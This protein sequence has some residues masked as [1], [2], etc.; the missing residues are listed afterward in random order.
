MEYVPYA[1]NLVALTSITPPGKLSERRSSRR[2][3]A[4]HPIYKF[5]HRC[6]F[7]SFLQLHSV[8]NSRHPSSS[9]L[10]Q[11]S[12]A[13]GVDGRDEGASFGTV[14]ALATNVIPA[15]SP[16]V[17]YAGK[18]RCRTLTSAAVLCSSVT[19]KLT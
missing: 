17:H 13:V 19:N 5:L 8:W 3:P 7:F 1:H 10:E 6:Y 4:A 14:N 11:L 18:P 9:R 15:H 2:I 16:M 12:R